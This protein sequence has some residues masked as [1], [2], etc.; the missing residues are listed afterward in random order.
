MSACVHVKTPAS[1]FTFGVAC[2]CGL[3]SAVRH[4]KAANNDIGL[5]LSKGIL[6]RGEKKVSFLGYFPYI[7]ANVHL[8]LNSLGPSVAMHLPN[9]QRYGMAPLSS[10]SWLWTGSTFFFFFFVANSLVRIYYCLSNIKLKKRHWCLF[11]KK[12]TSNGHL[13]IRIYI[14]RIM[15]PSRPHAIYMY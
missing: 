15:L 1:I 9:L 11:S 2:G 7:H 14:Y 12:L 4:N 3:E 13:S 8:E 6:V 10:N 5:S